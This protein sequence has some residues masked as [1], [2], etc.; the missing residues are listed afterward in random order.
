MTPATP[1]LQSIFIGTEGLGT[2]A[3]TLA[4]TTL[5]LNMLVQ[6]AFAAIVFL[7]LTDD[8]ITHET[9]MSF[10]KWRLNTAHQYRV[11]TSAF[12]PAATEDMVPVACLRACAHACMHAG[13][14]FAV[15]GYDER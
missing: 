4:L 7:S 10:R 15:H 5:L 11:C 12:I 9:V 13:P 2:F 8:R 1:R 14:Y 3:S 6:F